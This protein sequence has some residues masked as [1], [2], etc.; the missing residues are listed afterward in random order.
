MIIPDNILTWLLKRGLTDKVIRDNKLSWNGSQIVIPIFDPDG[1]FL[2]NKYRRDPFSNDG[3][4]Y[5][6]DAGSS[7]QLFHADRLEKNNI[8]LSVIVVEGEMDAMRLEAEGLLAVSSTGGSGTWRE[9]WNDL[10][11]GKMIFVCYDN[12]DA[13]LQGAVKLLTKIPAFMMIIPREPG[14]KDIT[15]YLTKHP[16]RDFTNLLISSREYPFFYNELPIPKTIK[17]A[18]Q[19]IKSYNEFL[20]KI[21]EKEREANNVGWPSFHFNHLRQPVLKMIEG[22]ERL[23]RKIRLD[24]EF[25]GENNKDT[26]IEEIKKAKRVPLE[27]LYTGR[28]T[29]SGNKLSGICPFHKEKEGSFVIFTDKNRWYCFGGC[30]QG[31]DAIDFLMKRD[32]CDFNTA[33]KTLAK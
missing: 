9:E 3:P 19:Q 15:D 8:H 30:S 24:N 29:R 14:I 20:G 31:G 5:K 22:R 13:G 26:F 7:A 16:I 4:K 10:L 1:K 32:G 28:L 27:T 23:I 25:S 12:D 21:L 6:Y 18:K 17:E 2:F 33:I 11:Q